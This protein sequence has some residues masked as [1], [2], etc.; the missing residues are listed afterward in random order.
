[1]GRRTAAPNRARA[2]W[3]RRRWRT[4]GAVLALGLAGLSGAPASAQ[5]FRLL[6]LDGLYLKWGKAAFGAPARVSYAILRADA[7]NPNGINCKSMTG[8][9]TLLA[10]NAIAE[11]TL[12]AELRAAFDLWRRV[13]G[14]QFTQTDDAATADIVIGAQARP[15]GI[16]YTNVE[17]APAEG[18]GFGRLTGAAICL[19]PT[20]AWETEGDDDL[21]TYNL[22]RVLAHEIGHA[23]GLNHF[24]RDDQLMGYAYASDATDLQ[25]GDVA[26]IRTLYGLAVAR[27][28]G[29]GEVST[30]STR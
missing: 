24:G 23:L 6:Q 29:E 25:A 3:Q 12:A 21:A 20:V 10:R 13:A 1:M 28:E 8:V 27:G 5:E 7:A 18:G 16:A 17:F 9:A 26:G 15:R 22:R 4:I 14:L 11:P 19:N 30:A 2:V